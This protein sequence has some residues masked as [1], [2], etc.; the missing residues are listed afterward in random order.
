MISERDIATMRHLITA[1][2]ASESLRRRVVRRS[3]VSSRC[4]RASEGG[5]LELPRVRTEF[6][7]RSFLYRAASAWNALAPENTQ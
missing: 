5:Y 1:P 3:D 4:T 2:D 7:R 6:A